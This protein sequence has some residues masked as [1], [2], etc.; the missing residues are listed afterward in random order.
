MTISPT[1]LA[2]WLAAFDKAVALHP[3][4]ADATAFFCAAFFLLASDNIFNKRAFWSRSRGGDEEDKDDV[5]QAQRKHNESLWLR[6][7]WRLGG[8][9]GLGLEACNSHS[10]TYVPLYDTLGPNAM[11]F[12]INHA[13][14]SIAFVHENK[15]PSNAYEVQSVHGRKIIGYKV[16]WMTINYPSLIDFVLLSGSMMQTLTHFILNQLSNT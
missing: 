14:V 11:E 3:L 7:R 1:Q 16:W 9:M 5:S 4:L 2:S 12:I 15:I 8:A 13:Q 10:V 6:V